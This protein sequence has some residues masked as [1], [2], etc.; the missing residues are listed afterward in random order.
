MTQKELQDMTELIEYMRLCVMNTSEK[1]KD[2]CTRILKILEKKRNRKNVILK[3]I[4]TVSA[5]VFLV[6]VMSIDSESYI[7]YYTASI[8]LLWIILFVIA[9]KD[10]FLA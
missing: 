4:T 7:P 5:I 1:E 2:K 10:T 3:A 8:S 9:N 6:S